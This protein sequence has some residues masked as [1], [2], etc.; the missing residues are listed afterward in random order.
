[1]KRHRADFFWILFF[2]RA[3]KSITPAGAGTGIKKFA[4]IT[5]QNQVS[6]MVRQ[7]HYERL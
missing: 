4:L 7:A 2:V 1:M 6:F 5:I 3:K